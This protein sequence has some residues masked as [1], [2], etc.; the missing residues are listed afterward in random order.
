MLK[1]FLDALEEADQVTLR[2]KHSQNDFVLSNGDIDDL[3]HAI[4]NRLE[5]LYHPR[6]F[7]SKLLQPSVSKSG[8]TLTDPLVK[9][10]SPAG[11]AIFWSVMCIIM[12]D[13]IYTLTTA[14]QA[15]SHAH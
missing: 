8:V 15:L 7:K 9:P 14:V 12:A 5:N 2:G 6:N 1:A 11:V 4:E 10:I 13:F 3:K